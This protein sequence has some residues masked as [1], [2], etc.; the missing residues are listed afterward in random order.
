[1]GWDNT[2][3]KPWK[4]R[5]APAS[6]GAVRVKVKFPWLSCR[7]GARYPMVELGDGSRTHLLHGVTVASCGGDGGTSAR[8]TEEVTFVYTRID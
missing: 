8:P 1:M 2:V 3:Q 4:T 5:A 6:R 7:V